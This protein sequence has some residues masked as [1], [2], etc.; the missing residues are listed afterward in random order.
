MHKYPAAAATLFT[1]FVA[2]TTPPD[3]SRILV[4]LHKQGGV[5]LVDDRR[6]TPKV[7]IRDIP[8]VYGI[9]SGREFLSVATTDRIGNSR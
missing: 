4:P 1:V 9:A 6:Q 7:E 2:F 8:G 3:A 5:L